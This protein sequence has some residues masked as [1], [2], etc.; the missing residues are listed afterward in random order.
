MSIGRFFVVFVSLV[1][2]CLSFSFEAK[3]QRLIPGQ[4]EISVSAAHGFRTNNKTGKVGASLEY[5]KVDRVGK[6]IFGLNWGLDRQIYEVEVFDEE[7]EDFYNEYFDVKDND[8][9][10]TGG[11]LGRIISN[12]RRSVILWGGL[13]AFVGA[14]IYTPFV[15]VD[16]LFP[17]QA[18]DV[19][20]VPKAN[21][22]YGFVPQ[23]R[24][25]LF[26]ADS[27]SLSAY[28][29]AHCQFYGKDDNKW[30]YPEIGFSLSYYFFA[31]K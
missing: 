13:T 17:D 2:F 10:F 12:R 23:I 19:S 27:F 7:I 11:Y 9:Y 16:P 15:E 14:R 28:F 20:L 18:P 8:L 3:A 25:E 6:C 1:A 26:P 5:A 30:F 31:G 22:I 4:S 29:K 21:F 24:F